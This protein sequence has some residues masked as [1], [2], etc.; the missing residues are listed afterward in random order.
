ML[1][2][3]VEKFVGGSVC[4]WTLTSEEMVF[5]FQKLINII[6]GKDVFTCTE[7]KGGR[8]FFDHSIPFEDKAG[9]IAFGGNNKVNDY[10]G[11][12]KRT[13]EERVQVYLT[14]E[15]CMRVRDWQR[16]HH[17][18]NKMEA[19]ITRVD[20]AFDDHNGVY[21]VN[22]CKQLFEAG[23]F[24]SSGRPPKGK[25]VDDF[26]S[27]EGRTF[28]VGKRDNGKILRCYEKGKQLGDENSPWVRW[29]VELH[30]KDREIP[31]DILIKPMEFLAGAYPALRFISEIAHVIKTA[32][33]KLKI[34]YTKLRTICRTQYGKL[35]NFAHRQLG[36][37]PEQIF[38]EFLNPAGFPDRLIWSVNATALTT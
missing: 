29:E 18:L 28:Y 34:Q 31:L 15:G 37:A 35:L 38:H 2:S 24:T 3:Q 32:R 1:R 13:V 25:M 16:V 22:Y 14:G 33:L 5:L 19:R 23:E 36:L 30:A 6:F 21:N 7:L 11:K 9:F 10:D 26:G 17:Y 27:G 12:T 4:G 20:P 8:N